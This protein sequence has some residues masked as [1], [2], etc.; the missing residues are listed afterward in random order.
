MVF[1]ITGVRPQ[2]LGSGPEMK[3]SKLYIDNKQG[4][5]TCLP[6][7]TDKKGQVKVTIQPNGG[8]I[9]AP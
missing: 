9:I 8:L 4:E 2:A 7:K 3:F 6:L 5:P 1:F